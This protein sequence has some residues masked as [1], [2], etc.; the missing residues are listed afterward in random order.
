MLWFTQSKQEPNCPAEEHNNGRGHKVHSSLTGRRH[1]RFFVIFSLVLMLIAAAHA[2]QS[3]PAR[4]DSERLVRHGI[5]VDFEALPPA[6]ENKGL[7]EGQLAEIRFRLTE[8]ATGAPV[9]GITPGAWMD[10]GEV[11]QGQPGAEQKTCKE[12]IALYL[13]GVIGIRPMIDL[14][15]YYV[16]VL[17]KE[18][19]ISVVDPLVS[20]VGKT[21]TLASVRL[22]AAGADWARSPD[23]KRVFV[24]M[25]TAG[26]VA[27]LDTTSF[28]VTDSIPAGTAP[29]RV[30]LQPDG[31]YLWVGNDAPTADASGVTVIDTETLEVLATIPTGAGH[32]EIAFSDDSRHAFVSNRDSGTVSVIDVESRSK[33]K[34]IATGPLPIS[35]AYS[36]LAKALY[37]ADGKDGSVSVV[38]VERFEVQKRIGASPG[39]GPLRFAPDGRFALVVNPSQNTVYVIDAA[40][41]EIVHSI[42]VT[43]QPYQVVFSRAF[44]YVRPL[45]SQS[46]FM[47]DLASVGAGKEPIVKSFEAG[48]VAPKLAGDLSLADSLA[49]TSSEAAMFI[50]N[51]GDNTTYVY[52]EGM[53]APSSNYMVRGARARGVMVVDRSL[54]E[55]EPGLFSAKVKLPAAGRYDVAF[56]LDTPQ[57]LHCF[58]ATAEPNPLLEHALAPL[59]I[60]YLLKDR[61]VSAGSPV[62]LRFRLVDPHTGEPRTGLKDVAVLYF[63]VPGADRKE[64]R[65]V[66]ESDG[67]YRAELPLPNPGAYYVHVGVPSERIVY[68]DLPYFTLVAAQT[69]AGGQRQIGESQP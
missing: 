66:E 13:K 40:A 62:P 16:L 24:T 5:V 33:L 57:I 41:N 17:N 8:E 1:G 44:A 43:G 7:V 35:L 39:L 15:S 58:S 36:S 21:S 51:P 68:Q 28:K 55:I 18:P 67:V 69:A 10:M 30:V 20:M 3:D 22:Q 61:R 14:N 11:I 63:R 46:I 47:I 54:H 64:V 45:A 49:A 52:M 19:T 48:N 6:G 50:V 12:K 2:E 26:K 4:A 9:R 29:T 34:D 56:V 53:N 31:R 59:A 25:P 38:D 27:L 42:A 37:V 32:H 65:A 23:E 60:E